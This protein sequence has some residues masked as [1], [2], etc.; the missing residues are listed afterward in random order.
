MNCSLKPVSS[1]AG[2]SSKGIAGG[3]ALPAGSRSA[4]SQTGAGVVGV[5][6]QEPLAP[7]FNDLYVRRENGPYGGRFLP[8]LS[9]PD[10]IH[11]KETERT[12]DWQDIAVLEEFLDARHLA[13]VKDSSMAVPAALALLRSRVGLEGFL[14]A[15]YLNDLQA[16]SLALAHTTHPVTEACSCLFRQRRPHRQ[17][18]LPLSR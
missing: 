4:G 8:F 17:R 3:H 9:L 2:R 12:T 5:L 16:V 13:R 1:P 15:G 6:A 10:L 7:P 11:S 18:H 14:Q